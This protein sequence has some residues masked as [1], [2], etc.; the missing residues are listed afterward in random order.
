[1]SKIFYYVDEDGIV[2]DT[3]RVPYGC[4]IICD[5]LKNEVW[6]CDQET[7]LVLGEY[8]KYSSLESLES[9]SVNTF[10]YKL[11]KFLKDLTHLNT[12]C[13]TIG[14]GRLANIKGEAQYFLNALNHKE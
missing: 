3:D 2:C 10:N 1:M 5:D 11:E 14:A 7:D 12:D 13:A 4:Y 8:T 6:L 9:V